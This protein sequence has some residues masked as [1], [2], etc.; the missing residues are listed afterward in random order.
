MKKATWKIFNFLQSKQEGRLITKKKKHKKQAEKNYSLQTIF[1]ALYARRQAAKS[2]RKKRKTFILELL[3]LINVY[4]RSNFQFKSPNKSSRK[5]Q[6][7]IEKKKERK[8]NGKASNY[9][10][11]IG[12]MELD[13]PD[14]EEHQRKNGKSQ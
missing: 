9:L 6:D 7:S 2:P 14:P 12:E 5:S 11:T 3:W 1:Q 8:E 13:N 4:R 10:S